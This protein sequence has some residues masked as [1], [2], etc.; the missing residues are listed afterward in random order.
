MRNQGSGALIIV[1]PVA[2]LA[3]R[4]FPH[5]VRAPAI[6]KDL[7]YDGDGATAFDRKV[8]S[9]FPIGSEERAM[10]AVLTH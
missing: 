4:T 3:D 5:A 10:H 9:E 6:A 7:P 8:K 2:P 1:A